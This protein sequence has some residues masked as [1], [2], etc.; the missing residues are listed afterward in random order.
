VDKTALFN[1]ALN[2]IG[3]RSNVASPTENSREAQVCSLWYPVV[4]GAVFEAAPWPEL[5]KFASLTLLDTR[6]SEAAWVNTNARPGYTFAYGLP[7]GFVRPQYLTNFDRFLMASYPG[8]SGDVRALATN[9]EDAIL[10]YTSATVDMDVWTNSLVLAMAYA[11]ASHVVMPL[12]GK[13][14]R[15]KQMVDQANN[16]ILQARDVAGNTSNEQFDSIPDWIAARG[17][18]GTTVSQ[19]YIYPYGDLLTVANV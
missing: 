4:Q 6:D 5:T 7:T 8:A 16:L 9:T 12:S 15:A 1:L 10:A 14:S 11:L 2:A 17:Y 18:S 19:R 13:V 3:A